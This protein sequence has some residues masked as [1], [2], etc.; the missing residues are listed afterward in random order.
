[1]A[2][3]Q[4]VR[5]SAGHSDDSLT[6]YALRQQVFSCPRAVELSTSAIFAFMLQYSRQVLYQ[7]VIFDDR[8]FFD[9]VTV[10]LG[11]FHYFD[12]TTTMLA[13]R[14]MLTTYM[15]YWKILIVL[16]KNG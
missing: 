13:I 4:S 7:E 9:Y 1:M 14:K 6:L 5:S 15:S 3:S 11:E 2:S 12:I 10:P 8:V 16:L